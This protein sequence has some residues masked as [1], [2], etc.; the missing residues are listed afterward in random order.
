MVDKYKAQ[1]FEIVTINVMTNQEEGAVKIMSQYGFKSLKNP[2]SG[3]EWSSE[4][5][6]VNGTPTSF[7]LDPDGK[8]VFNVPG[9]ES[10]DAVE[11][12]D[13]EIGGLLKWVASQ[14]PSGGQSK[15]SATKDR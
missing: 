2:G 9:L 12:C 6:G 10:A 14:N 11:T 4:T 15:I 5:Y 8:I 1:G 3:F 7:L 13:K